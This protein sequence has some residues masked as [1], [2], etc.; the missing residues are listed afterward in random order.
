MHYRGGARIKNGHLKKSHQ[1]KSRGS[2]IERFKAEMSYYLAPKFWSTNRI[3]I[4]PTLPKLSS[5]QVIQN[6]F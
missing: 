4:H 6:Y 5:S 3:P 1:R 2:Q